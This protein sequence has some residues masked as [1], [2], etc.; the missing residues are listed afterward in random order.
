MKK[1]SFL[2]MIPIQKYGKKERKPKKNSNKKTKEPINTA[3]LRI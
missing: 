2:L 3:L 1:K